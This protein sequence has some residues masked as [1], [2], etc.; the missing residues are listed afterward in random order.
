MVLRLFLAGLLAGGALIGAPVGAAHS[1]SEPADPTGTGSWLPAAEGTARAPGLA[2]RSGRARLGRSPGHDRTVSIRKARFVRSGLRP[3]RVPVER[4]PWRQLAMT[5]PVGPVDAAGVRMFEVSGRLYDH[6]VIQA[7]W[8]LMTLEAHR[9]SGSPGL[10]ATARAQ[11]DRLIER[12]VGVR[13][14]WFFPYRFD[15][16]LAARHGYVER[17]PWYSGM[18]QGEA[19][20]L[21]SQLASLPGIPASDR[22]RYRAAATASFRSLLVRPRRGVPW[23][24]M[25][26]AAGYLWLQEYPHEPVAASDYTFNGHVFALLG[27]Y[28]YHRLTGSRL[29]A[30]LF[31]GAATTAR[32]YAAVIR[33]PGSLSSYC[34]PHDVFREHYHQIHIELLQQLNWLTGERAFARWAARFAGDS[35]G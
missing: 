34:V 2:A 9:R 23:V 22:R 6:P 8:G 11:A 19:L 21:F 14:A 4:L 31:D 10:L 5:R 1:T 29:A 3:R 15:F 27:L 7:Q 33:R 26:D 24:S 25:V 13:R 17:A 12:R 18:A 35:A 28:D 30:R 32:H 20:S 16:V